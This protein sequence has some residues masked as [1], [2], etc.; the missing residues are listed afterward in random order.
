MWVAATV[1]AIADDRE[2]DDRHEV[3]DGQH[4]ERAPAMH[5]G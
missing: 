1:D 2:I 3:R 4:G 5:L